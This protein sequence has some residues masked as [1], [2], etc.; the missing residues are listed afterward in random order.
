MENATAVSVNATLVT[1]ATTVTAPQ[2]RRLACLTM[3]RCAV[4]GATASVGGASA[5]SRGHSGTRARNVQLVQMPV[6][7]KGMWMLKLTASF[8][9]QTK[10]QN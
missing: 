2:K 4:G 9:Y 7:Q 6:Q 8:L 1:L 3:A 5:V 10:V